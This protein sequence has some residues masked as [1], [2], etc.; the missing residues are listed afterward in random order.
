M[1][2]ILSYQISTWQAILTIV[3]ML[4]GSVFAY[5]KVTSQV[6]FNAK[7]NIE[8]DLKLD[9]HDVQRMSFI[10]SY[11]ENQTKQAILENELKNV[12]INLLE[13]KELLKIII[14]DKD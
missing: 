10:Q 13:V 8:Q 3:F 9:Y 7:K 2:K 4:G 11:N 1:P 12:N 5:A 14:K 6:E